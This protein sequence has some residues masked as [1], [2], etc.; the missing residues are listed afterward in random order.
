MG[1]LSFC[2]WLCSAQSILTGCESLSW[3]HPKQRK[4]GSCRQEPAGENRD[5]E[6]EEE[7]P[8]SPSPAA[9]EPG[10]RVAEHVIH[11]RKLEIKGEE[12]ARARCHP[13]LLPKVC[14]GGESN[15]QTHTLAHPTEP[16]SLVGRPRPT[17]ALLRAPRRRQR[18]AELS[19]Q[20]NQNPK[21]AG[22]A[23]FYPLVSSPQGPTHV[24]C[25]S[26]GCREGTDVPARQEQQPSV[27]P[28]KQ[29][30]PFLGRGFF[31][32]FGFLLKQKKPAAS[33]LGPRKARGRV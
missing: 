14:T 31:F 6:E 4:A 17:R 18:Q 13:S 7:A 11:G 19:K 20:K 10:S 3:R 16:V 22:G 23:F 9:A 27:T 30:F 28:K 29:L 25:Q 2:A 8:A 1:G 21:T 32:F 26:G 33:C 15:P 5:E 24:P 12:R